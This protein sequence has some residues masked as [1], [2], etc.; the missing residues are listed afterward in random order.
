MA[1]YPSLSVNPISLTEIPSTIDPVKRTR[2]ADGSVKIRAKFTDLIDGW[3]FRYEGLP[4]SDKESLW[5]FYTVTLNRGEDEFDWT[6]F[7]TSTVY[8]VTMLK[9]TFKR[10]PSSNGEWMGTIEIRRYDNT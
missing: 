7:E 6:H 8:S 1:S 5:T 3:I 9:P 4:N 10:D 2:R